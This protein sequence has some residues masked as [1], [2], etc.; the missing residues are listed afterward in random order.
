LCAS[1][2]AK[3]QTPDNAQ[4][5]ARKGQGGRR[6]RIEGR[7]A[8]WVGEAQRD[9]GSADPRGK[10]ALAYLT[11]ECCPQSLLAL[12]R[13]HPTKS[14]DQAAQWQAYLADLGIRSPRHVKI[15]TAAAVLG[16]ILHH[17]LPRGLMI[18]SDDEG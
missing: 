6:W 15:A 7:E 4:S 3:G 16:S 18:V 11:R 17:G 14:F 10:D 12:L 9:G 5:V 8:S 1:E 13:D 2:E